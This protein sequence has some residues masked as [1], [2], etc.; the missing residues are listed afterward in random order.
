MKGGIN[1]AKAISENS[2]DPST[3]V[4]AVIVKD[5]LIISTGYNCFPRG[6][7]ETEER[8]NDR[9]TK[10]A[11]VVHA[12][13]NAILAAKGNT[14]GSTMYCTLFPCNECAKLIIQSGVKRIVTVVPTLEQ[15]ERWK[16]SF[17]ISYQMLT[18]AGVE[19]L[20]E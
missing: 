1:L 20:Y 15:A 16:D 14:Q 10:Y 11:M 8:L 19:V 5:L 4:G 13:A 6:V 7:A 3:K 9:P 12:E 17:N 2:N 18:E